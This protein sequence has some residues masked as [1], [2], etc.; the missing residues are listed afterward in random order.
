MSEVAIPR[1][2]HLM[3]ANLL[4]AFEL[5]R[6][7]HNDLLRE[8]AE[9]RLHDS[10]SLLRERRSVSLRR[11]SKPNQTSISSAWIFQKDRPAD[12]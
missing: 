6:A 1:I 7:R 5:H 3:Y 2:V 9:C 11:A 12:L 8:A 10:A 4:F